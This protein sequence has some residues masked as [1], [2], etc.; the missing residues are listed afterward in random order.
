MAA[1]KLFG[2]IPKGFSG[3]AGMVS[4]NITADIKTKPEED[5]PNTLVGY[6]KRL[7]A[8]RGEEEAAYRN[9]LG[10]QRGLQQQWEQEDL[11]KQADQMRQLDAQKKKAFDVIYR[12]KALSDINFNRDLQRYAAATANHQISNQMPHGLRTDPASGHGGPWLGP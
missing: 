5:D 10:Y 6:K 1:Q 11:K 12:P 4:P 2:D 8:Q 7:Q 3:I 9:K